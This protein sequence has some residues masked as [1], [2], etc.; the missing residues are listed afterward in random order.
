[1]PADTNASE[2]ADST[3]AEPLAAA[4]ALG[5]APRDSRD[6]GSDFEVPDFAQWRLAATR[7]AA[8]YFAD[9]R[10]SP[11]QQAAAPEICL[12]MRRDPNTSYLRMR[13]WIQRNRSPLTNQHDE[14]CFALGFGRA[15]SRRG[16]LTISV[17]AAEP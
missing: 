16:A 14:A 11:P 7:F 8:C 12:H 4:T 9:L 17:A 2:V 10:R 13:G 15:R 5:S 1:M 6:V 3:P